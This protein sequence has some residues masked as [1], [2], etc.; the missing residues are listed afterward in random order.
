MKVNLKKTGAK[1]ILR[2][3]FVNLIRNGKHYTW[4]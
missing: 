4:K 2:K 1:V 3:R